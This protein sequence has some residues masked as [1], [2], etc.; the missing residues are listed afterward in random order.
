MEI[1]IAIKILAGFG[2]EVEKEKLK[3]LNPSKPIKDIAV[4]IILN[5]FLLEELIK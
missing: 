3:S 2:S 5:K 1:E 4:D